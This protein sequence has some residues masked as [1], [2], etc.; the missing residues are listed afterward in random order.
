MN[1]LL[2]SIQVGLPKQLGTEGA[3]NR[4]DRPWS[5]GIF[6][7]PVT[8]PIW[9][10]QTN[11]AGDGQ[12]ELSVHGGP[13]MAVLGYSAEHY[14]AWHQE[15]AP[16]KMPY[17]AFGENFTISGQTEQSVCIGDTYIVG[18]AKLQVSQP[19]LPCWKLARKWQLKNLPSLV[20]ATGRVGWYFRVLS[21]GYVESGLPMKLLERPFPRWT[22]SQVLSI[23]LDRKERQMA[24]ELATCPLLA[25]TW[26]QILNKRAA[27]SSAKI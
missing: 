15:L 9:L 5:S 17:G 27:E 18:E 4:M 11:L 3:A 21:A 6:K 20:L 10:G 22:I 24:A 8:G 1:P 14:P 25:S 19:R 13:E 12:S 7:Q 16:L 26:Q 23:H 2:V